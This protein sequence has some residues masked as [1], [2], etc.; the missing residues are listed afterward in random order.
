M[1]QGRPGAEP[2]VDRP[3]RPLGRL[4]GRPA[5]WGSAAPLRPR[6]PP[7]THRRVTERGPTGERRMTIEP[8]RRRRGALG[9]RA[10]PQAW[11]RRGGSNGTET[12]GR[13]AQVKANGMVLEYETTGEPA[14]P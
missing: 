9:S 2:D 10:I 1:C 3:Y 11:H 12:G 13:M 7:A 4:A 8:E 6:V 14:D 5:G